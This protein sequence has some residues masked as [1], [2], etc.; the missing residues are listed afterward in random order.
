[1]YRAGRPFSCWDTGPVA[2]HSISTVAN[3]ATVF[4]TLAMGTRI[5]YIV[6]DRDIVQ[7]MDLM[8][9]HFGISLRLFERQQEIQQNIDLLAIV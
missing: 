6:A 8:G 4:L 9:R 7:H 5:G 2:D 1:M 3:R